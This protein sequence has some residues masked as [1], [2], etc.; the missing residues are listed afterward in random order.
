MHDSY[1]HDS[2]MLQPPTPTA[3]L[4]ERLD[5]LHQQLDS[6]SKDKPAVSNLVLL[7]QSGEDRRQGGTCSMD[8]QALP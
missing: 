7:G 6:F 8:E 3:S 4:E 1:I 5:F 2:V